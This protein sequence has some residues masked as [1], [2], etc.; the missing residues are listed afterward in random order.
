LIAVDLLEVP[1]LAPVD[2]LVACTAA[3]SGVPRGDP[4]ER[5]LVDF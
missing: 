3:I 1:P 5:R 2:V 4:L